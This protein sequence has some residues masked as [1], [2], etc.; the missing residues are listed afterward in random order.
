MC[1]TK[2]F[3]LQ[4]FLHTLNIDN[5][6]KIFTSTNLTRDSLVFQLPYFVHN[7]VGKR[8]RGIIRS[9]I[10]QDHEM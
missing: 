5:M 4:Q 9:L 8:K 2:K 3:Q 7:M 1:Y 10:L 6:S